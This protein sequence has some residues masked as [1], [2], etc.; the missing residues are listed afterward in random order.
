MR[1]QKTRTDIFTRQTLDFI[2]QHLPSEKPRILE[3]GCG[4][5]DLAAELMKLGMDVTALDVDIEAVETCKQ[6]GIHAVHQDILTFADDPFDAI[7]FTRSLHHIPELELALEKAGELLNKGGRVIIEDFDLE[8]IDEY[9]ARWYYDMRS[10]VSAFAHPNTALEY[11]NDPI[12]Q[13]E[14]D[15]HHDH[16]LHSGDRMQEECQSRFKITF[17][18]RNPYL[19]RSICRLL[20]DNA[21]SYFITQQVLKTEKGLI[22]K[23]FILPNGLRIVAEKSD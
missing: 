6:K 3:V 22:E 7:L 11:V 18:G 20:P 15:H 8:M 23:K 9:S 17:T 16:P 5:G 12:Q 10:I 4:H 21:S 14:H 19:Y 1:D 2:L 13:W